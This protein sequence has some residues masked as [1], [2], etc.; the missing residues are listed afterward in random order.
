MG[1]DTAQTLP[2]TAVYGTTLSGLSR[3]PCNQTSDWF[4]L[5]SFART[6]HCYP[7]CGPDSTLGHTG[8]RADYHLLCAAHSVNDAAA[9]I[10]R[11]GGFAALGFVLA[12]PPRNRR[13]GAGH[14]ALARSGHGSAQWLFGPG[15]LGALAGSHLG[16]PCYHGDTQSGFVYLQS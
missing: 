3:A 11:G 16:A 1:A 12:G 9:Q 10:K 2:R 6:H 7:L 15:P 8:L 5:V 14:L 4:C 13:P